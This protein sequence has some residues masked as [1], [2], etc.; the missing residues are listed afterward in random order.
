MLK[1]GSLFYATVMALIIAILSSSLML[2][3]YFKEQEKT[4]YLAQETLCR[5]VISGIHLAIASDSLIS[6]GSS[7]SY[8]LFGNNTDSVSIEKMNWGSY[9]VILSKAFSRL[10]SRRKAAIIGFLPDSTCKAALYLQD[11]GKPLTLCGKTFVRG[12]CY[13]PQSGVKRGNMEG[14]YFNG[15]ELINGKIKSSS[16]TMPAIAR[17]AMD[18]MQS[19][20]SARKPLNDSIYSP[21]GQHDSIS[22][23]FF[24]KTIRIY[25]HDKVVLSSGS[26]YKGNIIITS[27]TEVIV[28]GNCFAKDII[29]YAPIVRIESLFNGDLQVYGRD[30]I[31]VAKEVRFTYP[32]VLGIIK[33]KVSTKGS[34][35]LLG[36]QVSVAGNIFGYNEMEST[37]EQ[38]LVTIGKDDTISGQVYTNGE[39]DIRGIVYGNITCSHFI[40]KSSKGVY[41]D[42]LVDVTIDMDNRSKYFLNSVLVKSTAKSIVK[43]VY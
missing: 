32:S 21:S 9:Q 33:N 5:N 17:D 15:S 30:S 42:Y 36:S 34:D 7:K 18:Q 35:I 22:N 39:V 24:N 13:L 38:M 27:D 41:E 11:N 14:K 8:D 3:S 4:V 40:T 12:I 23:S 1:A 16:Y 43:W 20:F 19:Y 26:Y 10:K 25:S 6:V 2:F 37:N 28:S 31:C 29:I